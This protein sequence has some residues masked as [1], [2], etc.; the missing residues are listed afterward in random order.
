M[1]SS[2]EPSREE[3]MSLENKLQAVPEPKETA[4]ADVF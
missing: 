3:I 2:I 4:L 1:R